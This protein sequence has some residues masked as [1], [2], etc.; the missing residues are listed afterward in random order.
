MFKGIFS[1]RI[2]YP[3]GKYNPTEDECDFPQP[4]SDPT[5]QFLNINAPENEDNNDQRGVP[6]FWL[7]ILKYVPMFDSMVK[8][9]D[10]PLLQ[11]IFNHH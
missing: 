4:V 6:N 9:V 3:S 2:V 8:E 1:Y 11:V 10:E 7:N 5:I